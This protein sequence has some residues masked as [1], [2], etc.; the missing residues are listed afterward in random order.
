[1]APQVLVRKRKKSLLYSRKTV[2]RKAI[3]ENNTKLRI[4]SKF[5]G[6]NRDGY[7]LFFLL[8]VAVS[9]FTFSKFMVP[10]KNQQ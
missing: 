6:K 1:M 4:I 5:L 2:S 7:K 9:L 8:F 10:K 3:Q